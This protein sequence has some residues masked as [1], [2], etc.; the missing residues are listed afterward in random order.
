MLAERAR[1]I[2]LM[3]SVGKKIDAIK[4]FRYETSLGL[5]QA[6]DY[7]EQHFLAGEDGLRQKLADDFVQNS[8]DLLILAKEEKKRL[9]AY[10][11]DLETQIAEEDSNLT[12]GQDNK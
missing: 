10:I 11:A 6:K 8:Q 2:A 4:A 9:E 7:L 12:E 5:T 1:A 3:W